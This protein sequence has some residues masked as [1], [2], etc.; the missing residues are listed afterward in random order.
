VLAVSTSPEWWSRGLLWRR[1]KCA[2]CQEASGNGDSKGP[3]VQLNQLRRTATCPTCG[4]CG[5][6]DHNAAMNLRAIVVCLVL[7]GKRPKY[8]TTTWMGQYINAIAAPSR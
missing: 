2:L 3:V 8:T 5:D 4:F 1:Q 7:T 6:R